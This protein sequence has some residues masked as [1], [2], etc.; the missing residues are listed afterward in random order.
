MGMGMGNG[1]CNKKSVLIKPNEKPKSKL[2]KPLKRRRSSIFKENITKFSNYKEKYK[3]ISDLGEG[4]FGYV[5]LF[6]DK[7]YPELKFAIKTL[8]KDLLQTNIIL[9][10]IDEVKILRSVDHPNIV[11]YFET[12]EEDCRIHIV[13]EY[14]PGLNLNE[15]INYKQKTFKEEELL[16]LTFYILKALSFLHR[17]NIT[18]RDLKPENILL[19]NESDISSVKL[20]DFG[21]STLEEK[22]KEKYRVGSPYYMAP[23]MVYGNYSPASDMWS[24]GVILYLLTTNIQPFKGKDSKEIYKNIRKGKYDKEALV[25]RDL[26]PDLINFIGKLLL[27]DESERLKSDAAF[28]DPWIIKYSAKNDMNM[29]STINESI[30]GSLRCFSKKNILQK[31]SIFY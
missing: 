27:V 23:E 4:S 14:I 2:N 19:S 7:N 12:Y 9:C 3:Y 25:K 15:L 1:C 28:E 5:R 21:L 22:K 29:A 24:L 13:T 8:Q 10:L 17:M 20:I 18:H 30:L 26:N 6:C 11:K 31:I 16:V